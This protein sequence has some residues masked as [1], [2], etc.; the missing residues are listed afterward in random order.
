MSHDENSHV[1]YSWR[2]FRGQGFAHD[3]LMHGPLQFHM[4]ALSYFVFGDGDF[5]ARIPAALFSIA[6]VAFMWNYRRYLGR[7]GALVAAVLMLISP[8]ML[9][10]GRYVRNEAYVAFL[11][12]VTIWAILR[13]L[14]S[15]KARY[16][17]WLTAVTALHF[18]ACRNS[19]TFYRKGNILHL[20]CP[21]VDILAVLFCISDLSETLEGLKE[22][23]FIP[24]HTNFRSAFNI[25]RWSSFT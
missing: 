5:T 6:T 3:P 11:G 7:I 12:V 17:Y 13:Y 16:L 25:W 24:H 10:Y 1:Y 9:Y 21:G 18:T 20:H 22:Q 14:E 2:L 19:F 23:E 8:Y 15:G 4:L